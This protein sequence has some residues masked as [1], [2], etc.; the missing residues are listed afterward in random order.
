[1]ALVVGGTLPSKSK[2]EYCVR[3]INRGSNLANINNFLCARTKEDK[4]F[5]FVIYLQIYGSIIKNNEINLHKRKIKK[6]Y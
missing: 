3:E 5:K 1:V 2:H 6:I 4:K